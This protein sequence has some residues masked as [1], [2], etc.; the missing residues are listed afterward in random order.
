MNKKPLCVLLGALL[1]CPQESA[2]AESGFFPISELLYMR[3]TDSMPGYAIR[4]SDSDLSVEGPLIKVRPDFKPG[5][6]A[7]GGYHFSKVGDLRI[8]YSHLETRDTSSVTEPPNGQIWTTLDQGTFLRKADSAS[9]ADEFAYRVLDL[10]VGGH[11]KVLNRVGLRAFGGLRYAYIRRDLIVHYFGDAF[12]VGGDRVELKNKFSGLGLR[13]GLDGN[14]AIGNGFLLE[15]NLAGAFMAGNY[16]S[17]LLQTNDTLPNE[18][19]EDA[20]KLIP[21]LETSLGFGY[22]RQISDH[23][24]L[25]AALGYRFESWFGLLDPLV[26]DDPQVP[27]NTKNLT[28]DGLFFRATAR[29]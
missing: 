7:G 5:L 26:L 13:G 25:N 2:L 29:F 28:L 20:R 21:A 24:T 6:R 1:L 11:V 3:P 12:S 16:H 14:F 10:E 8:V 18:I 4:D 9:A 17:R 22:E 15:T 27:V 19:I 23:L